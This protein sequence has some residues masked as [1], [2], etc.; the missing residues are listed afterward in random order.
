MGLQK[1]LLYIRC[2]QKIRKFGQQVVIM[3]DQLNGS[4]EN[5]I[6]LDKVFSSYLSAC[7]IDYTLIVQEFWTKVE[8]Q[9]LAGNY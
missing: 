9:I 8:V 4:F 6:V 7:I 1:L 3:L 2:A 5:Q